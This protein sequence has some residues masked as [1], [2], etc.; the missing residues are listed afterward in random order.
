MPSLRNSRFREP[1]HSCYSEEVLVEERGPSVAWRAIPVSFGRSA[2]GGSFAEIET[3]G[4]LA[5]RLGAWLTPVHCH[6]TREIRRFGWSAI[7]K[8]C[9]FDPPGHLAWHALHP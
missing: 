2:K 3:P 8:R 5:N 6:S 1:A 9:S 4:S 7:G